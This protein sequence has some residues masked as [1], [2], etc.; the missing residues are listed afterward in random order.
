VKT[1]AVMV[2]DLRLICAG[3]F[4]T[5]QRQFRLQLNIGFFNGV[6]ARYITPE[7]GVDP[8]APAHAEDVTCCLIANRRFGPVQVRLKPPRPIAQFPLDH[9]E[10][11][12]T[13]DYRNLRA[14]TASA[15]AM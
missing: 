1:F 2:N 14:C 12:G 6:P 3:P 5:C 13:C 15:I 4:W 7:V 9:G 10:R 8:S 11:Q